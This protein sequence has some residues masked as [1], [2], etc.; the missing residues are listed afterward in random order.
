MSRAAD[1]AEGAAQETAALVPKVGRARPLAE[2]SVGHPD[3]GAL[4]FAI[5]AR[6]LAETRAV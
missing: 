2:R 5:I 4:S 6:T 1:A 3:P